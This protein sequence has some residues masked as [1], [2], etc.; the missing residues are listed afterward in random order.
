MKL[1]A[2][3]D[4]VPSAFVLLDKDYRIKTASVAFTAITGYSLKEVLGKNCNTILYNNGFF[5]ERISN[6]SYSSG[7]TD[8][9]V[10]KVIDE[11]GNE[12]FIEQIIIPIKE[13]GQITSI[14]EIITD[15]TERKQLEQNLI[16]SEKLMAAGEMSA[17][18]AHEFR[19]LLTSVK[20]ILQLQNETINLS[21][22][23]KY[24]LGVAL[25]S[26]DHME[27]IVNELL[28]F[29]SPKP[30]GFKS[31]SLYEVINESVKFVRPQLNKQNI[32]FNN[33]V[34]DDLPNLMLDASHFKEALINVLLNAIQ[35]FNYNIVDK[36]KREI[37]I[38][39][40]KV[41]LKKTLHDFS[42]EDN[43]ENK[44]EPLT[45]KE[46]IL[47]KGSE[48]ALIEINDNGCGIGNKDL[49]RIFDPFFTTKPNGTGLG[50]PMVKRTINAH[51]GIIIAESQKRNG[52]TFN[53]FLPLSNL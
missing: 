18:I 22:S 31:T 8:I 40:R 13:D 11:K 43:I 16:H 41:K 26:I 53:M 3:I 52:T 19:N 36:H 32:I 50:L 47:R 1:Q 27:G 35:A 33:K 12:R 25:N 20:I 17:I 38:Y 39:I 30:M 45:R 37:N 42:F 15:I 28:N 9:F 4:N 29:A 23:E 24:S 44:D 51:D 14:L 5:K 10:N 46:I 34:F 21:E 7:I 48:C 49:K 2:I 6:K